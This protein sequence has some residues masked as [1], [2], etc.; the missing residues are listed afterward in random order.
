MK[1]FFIDVVLL[2]LF[3]AELS[4][5]YLPK[6]LHEILGVIMLA[7]AIFHVAIN[8]RRFESLFKDISPKKF[9]AIEINLALIIAMAIILFTGVC[10]SNYLFPDVV[11]SSL[12]RSVT[13]QNLHKSAPYIMLILIGVHIGLHWRELRGRLLNLLKLETPSRAW[14]IFYRAV[15]L[16]LMIFGATGLF[17]NRVLDRI[18]MKHIFATPATDL[19]APVFMLMIAGGIMIFALITRVVVGKIFRH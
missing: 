16:T 5:H 15:T 2:A 6:V 13:I 4:F 8:F 18:L 10:M 1:N 11:G 19:P 7:L 9:F 17:L 14:K 3:V 12:R